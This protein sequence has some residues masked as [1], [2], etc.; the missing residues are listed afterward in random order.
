MQGLQTGRFLTE[1]NNFSSFSEINECLSNPCAENMTCFDGINQFTCEPLS[2]QN[3][4]Q[5]SGK[6]VKPR[7][8][9]FQRSLVSE[10][11]NQR[12]TTGP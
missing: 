7:K 10:G 6:L 12:F 5:V 8:V 9:S 3:K 2:I 4:P 1:L 11:R